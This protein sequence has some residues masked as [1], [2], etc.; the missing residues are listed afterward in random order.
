MSIA[1]G[2]VSQLMTNS[3]SVDVLPAASCNPRISMSKERIEQINIH[4]VNSKL[5]DY[6]PECT[7]LVY[8]DASGTEYGGYDVDTPSGA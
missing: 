8:T 4:Y 2:S 6:Q 1:I 3:L 5:L 7:K